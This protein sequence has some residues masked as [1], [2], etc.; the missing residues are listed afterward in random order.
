VP[1]SNGSISCVSGSPRPGG[2]PV[3]SN[4]HDR[5]GTTPRGA[6]VCLDGLCHKHVNPSDSLCYISA[7]ALSGLGRCRVTVHRALPCADACQGVALHGGYHPGRDGSSVENPYANPLASRTGC[8][9]TVC[10]SFLPNSHSSRNEG[11]VIAQT[12]VCPCKQR[13]GNAPVS[14]STGQRPVIPSAITA[15]A[16]KGRK[17]GYV[18]ACALSGL[19]CCRV[20]IHRALPC[21]DACQGVALSYRIVIKSGTKNKNE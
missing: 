18:S 3:Y 20:I 14:S 11:A 1:R 15:E 13:K 10:R 16:L 12:T 17:P 5:R 8:N 9:I 19:G 7:H 2:L 21:A 4:R 6:H